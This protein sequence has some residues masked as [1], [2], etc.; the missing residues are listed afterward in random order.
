[1]IL[2]QDKAFWYITGGFLLVILASQVSK[3]LNNEALSFII[4]VT[5]FAIVSLL[6]F[7]LKTTPNN[8]VSTRV[9]GIKFRH[10]AFIIA[11]AT[12]LSIP[13]WFDPCI[14]TNRIQIARQALGEY[15]F[16]TLVKA[17]IYE[18]FYFRGV[19]LLALQKQFS[20]NTSAQLNGLCFS[21]IHLPIFFVTNVGTSIIL[22]LLTGT[23]GYL[24][25]RIQLKYGNLYFPIVL[26]SISNL[27]L[28]FV[29]FPS[30]PSMNSCSG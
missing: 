13:F 7:R 19:L 2:T 12:F 8:I 14:N 1:M 22:I 3:L 18:E 23:F 15:S 16:S 4:E 6:T 11:I 21:M 9:F 29:G 24:L 26:H 20:D 10:W 5:G 27:L 28:I 25:A 30:I 17:P